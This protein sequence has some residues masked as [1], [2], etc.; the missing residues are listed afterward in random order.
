MKMYILIRD[1]V[2]LGI[3]MTAAAHASLACYLKF[4]D[5]EAV[6]EWLSGPF[7]KVICKVNAQQLEQAKA[8]EDHV[9]M[10]ESSLDG[11]EVAA[12]FCP[13]EAWPKSFQ[14]LSLYR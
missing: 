2:P 3:A 9:V 12:A 8:V 6:T 13:R 14:F 10:T 1:D 5:R 4:Q 11:R 7:R